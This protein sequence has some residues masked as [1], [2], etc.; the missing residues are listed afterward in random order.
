MKRKR[1]VVAD[2]CYFHRNGVSSGTR[3]FCDD[4]ISC[5]STKPSAS[6]ENKRAR[7][8]VY[9]ADQTLF[10][11]LFI[12]YKVLDSMHVNRF[13]F[14]SLPI[15]GGM[16]CMNKHHEDREMNRCAI[17][18]QRTL[19]SWVIIV[20]TFGINT[21]CIAPLY[22]LLIH[23]NRRK[24]VYSDD[25][26]PCD[27]IRS[28]EYEKHIFWLLGEERF[29]MN[30]MT[31]SAENNLWTKIM[32]KICNRCYQMRSTDP[33]EVRDKSSVF[34]THWVP[35]WVISMKC[36]CIIIPRMTIWLAVY[37]WITE[38]EVISVLN[39]F[40]VISESFRTW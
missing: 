26:R 19:L 39:Y 27:V 3:L 10:S 8:C 15:V 38:W 11:F 31:T 28:L 17:T 6:I 2:W 18:K 16:Y 33:V 32:V 5:L 21:D 7:R 29:S 34:S 22:H 30:V 14:S 20:N 25:S 4:V 36:I 9:T 12:L 23:K 1:H 13:F 35:R 37:S 24:L 40:V